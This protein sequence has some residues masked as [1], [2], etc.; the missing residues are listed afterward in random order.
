M[1]YVLAIGRGLRPEVGAV[2]FPGTRKHDLPTNWAAIR[3]HV[4]ARDGWRC[5]WTD[6]GERCTSRATD[7]DHIGN[8]NDHRPVNLR[9]L[10]P[11]HHRK[12]TARQGVQARAAKYD[13]RRPTLPHPGLVTPEVV[14]DANEWDAATNAL[15]T[16]LAR[17]LND[18]GDGV[19]G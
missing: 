10:C 5:V 4:L 17:S 3:K 15:V 6:N 7:V 14:E 2:T 16:G 11:T 12:R 9:S 13:P 19:G 18:A 8:R 1:V